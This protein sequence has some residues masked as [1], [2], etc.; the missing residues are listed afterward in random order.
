MQDALGRE[1]K[2]GDPVIYWSYA[3]QIFEL[4]YVADQ[5]LLVTQ[6]PEYNNRLVVKSRASMN[7]LVE[8]NSVW[9]IT[10]EEALLWILQE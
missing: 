10:P 9:L 5:T 8:E 7:F 4:L 6:G 1:L 2:V 3:Q